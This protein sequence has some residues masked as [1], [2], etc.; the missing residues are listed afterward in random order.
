MTRIFFLI[1]FSL[2]PVIASADTAEWRRYVI[3][4]TAANVD[5]PVSIFT[6]DAGPPESGSGRRFYTRDRRADLTLQS[7]PN[8]ENDSP[9]EFLQKKTTASGYSVQAS[10]VWLFCRI[11]RPE[12]PNVVQSLQPRQRIHELRVGQLSGGGRA[13]V[14]WDRHSN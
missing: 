8:P 2:V 5:I 9:A 14:G 13:E 1:V 7:V 4:G 12:R 6:E 11:E 3:P 10:N